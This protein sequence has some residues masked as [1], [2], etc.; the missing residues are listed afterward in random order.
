MKVNI[1]KLIWDF[2][3][4][5]NPTNKQTEHQLPFDL[6]FWKCLPMM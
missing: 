5:G 6:Y 2:S 1:V 4:G 3:L